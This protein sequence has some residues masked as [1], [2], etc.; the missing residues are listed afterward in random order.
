MDEGDSHEIA[1]RLQ[2]CK[3]RTQSMAN[4]VGIGARV[5]AIRKTRG[6][7]ARELARRARVSY[8][9]LTKAEAGAV[10]AT[11]ALIG[12][13]AQALGV[14][15]T[16]ITGQPY[17]EPADA[18]ALQTT[19][20]PL[21]R[22]LLAY[23]LPPETDVGPRATDELRAEVIA[24]SSLGRQARYL[25]L[26][27]R[28]P[29][30]LDELQIAIAAADEPDRPALYAL[31][32]EAYGGISGLAHQLG[33]ADLRALTLDRIEWA[34]R[35]SGDPLRVARTQWSRGAS[36]LAAA[37]YDQGLELMER[38]RAEIGGGQLGELD[39][40]A[41]SVY[42]SLHLRSAVLAARAGRRQLSDAHLAEAQDVAATV[43]AGANHYGMEFGSANVAVHRVSVA[44]EM[45]D[46]ALALTRAGEVERARY[47]ASLPPVRVGHYYIEVARAWLYHGDSRRALGALRRARRVAPEQTRCHPMV[48]EAVRAIAH[49]E[50]RPNEELR[51]FAAWL[52]I[53][54]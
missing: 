18:A 20:G 38:T 54:S 25:Q 7:T 46:G 5:A 30:L 29:G 10:P 52:G 28:L 3:S 19:V 21:R 26:S 48:R 2:V 42:G 15:V 16:R 24:V 27:Q 6:W 37:A 32:A 49:A 50:P 17:E 34:A 51:S 39:E 4:R 13:V 43:Q 8:S 31:L 35:L 40:P 53:D 11:P 1:N 14:D 45:A 41:R 44:V 9:L 47:L 23:D 36:L 33:Y 12:A 22:A